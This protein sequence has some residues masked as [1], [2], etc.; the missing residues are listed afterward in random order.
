MGDAC[1]PFFLHR[2]DVNPSGLPPAASVRFL[3]DDPPL[4]RDAFFRY[5]TKSIAPKGRSYNGCAP[6]SLPSGI[7]RCGSLIAPKIESR[8]VVDRARW[9]ERDLQPAFARIPFVDDAIAE[10]F[11]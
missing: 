3:S 1:W 8:I 6:R 10:R 7:Y 2:N 9:F 5:V 4:G 11:H